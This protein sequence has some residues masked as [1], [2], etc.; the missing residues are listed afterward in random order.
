MRDVLKAYR[1]E[2]REVD[3]LQFKALL[4]IAPQEEKNYLEHFVSGIFLFM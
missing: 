4:N 2:H 3:L 1:K